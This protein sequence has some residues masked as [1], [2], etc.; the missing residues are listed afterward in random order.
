MPQLAFWTASGERKGDFEASAEVFG[1]SLNRDL[2]HQA[3]KVVDS[4]RQRK[5]G[6]AKP[7]RDV[8]VTGAKM[9]RQKGLGRA[10]HGDQAPPHFRGGGVAH[11][12]RGDRRMLEM[13][14]KAR[15]AALHIAL[16]AQV[17]RGRVLVLEALAFTEP[18][19]KDM[20]ALLEA[21]GV[22][23]KVLLLASTDEARDDNNYL[24][25]RNLPSLVLRETPH[26]NPRDVLWADYVV[27]TQAGL[28]V[29]TG[30]GAPDA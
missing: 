3:V 2:L 9:Y 17:K 8:A 21:L 29:L 25:C 4:R 5:A 28:Q 14:K 15:R 22:A 16:S 18:R 12:P 24:S 6:R 20:V 10:R 13:P 30:G 19:T 27:F 23:G 26:F 11:P 1:V 7:R